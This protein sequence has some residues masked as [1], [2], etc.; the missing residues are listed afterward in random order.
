MPSVTYDFI[1]GQTVYVV[2]SGAI[3]SG[4]VVEV[5][6]VVDSG[7]TTTTYWVNIYGTLTAYTSGVYGSC[8]LTSGR[9]DAV[10]SGE[11]SATDVAIP[12]S[13][14]LYGSPNTLTATITVDGGGSPLPVLA[15]LPVTGSPAITFQDVLDSLN[16]AVAGIAV[17][18]LYQN[19]IRIT[20]LA[21]G[22]SSSVV[23]T[24]TDYFANLNTFTGLA[25]PV[26]GTDAGALE[27][28]GAAIC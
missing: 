22:S 19:N 26:A 7:G 5:R 21:T 3:K 28:L 18:T 4:P 1:P 6:I 15:S 23:I 16:A 25:A 11:L 24:D 13:S 14:P 20:S 9:A 10:F 8:Q 2:D 17:A 27:A 12:A